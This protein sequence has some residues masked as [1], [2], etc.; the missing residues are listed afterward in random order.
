MSRYQLPVTLA[1]LAPI[2]LSAS[3]LR[4]G[5]NDVANEEQSDRR[6]VP[7]FLVRA[8][9]SSFTENFSAGKVSPRWSS[10][11]DWI[12]EDGVLQRVTGGKNTTR[13][14]LK[15]TAFSNAIVRFD[16]RLGRSRDLRLVTGSGGHYNAV[17]HIQPD[18]FYLQTAR[19]SDGPYFSRRHGECAYDFQHNLWYSMT[20][21]FLDHELVAYLD[22]EHIAYAEHP[23][24]NKERHY[25]AFQVDSGAAEIDNVQITSAVTLPPDQTR[26]A[27][28][29]E[30]IDDHPV[31]RSLADTYAIEKVNAHDRLFQS[32]SEYR[33]LVAEVD[34]LDEV[35][36]EQFPE[37]FRTRK[38]VKKDISKLRKNLLENE[39]EYK[40]LLFATYRAKR[41]IEQ[42]VI[43]EHPEYERLPDSQRKH[44]LA[45]WSDELRE[46]FEYQEL[47]LSR[48]AAQKQLEAAYPQLFVSDD[49]IRESQQL[50]RTALKSDPAFQSLMKK[51]ADAW[52]HQQQYLHEQDATLSEIHRQRIAVE[53]Q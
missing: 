23:I 10:S 12:V 4:G 5:P 21:E 24:L 42:Y 51:R 31:E 39:P 43:S 44:H 48:V 47:E 3:L 22:A 35:K 8:T 46:T 25:F 19:D 20:L 50:A 11:A 41:S 1:T 13:I 26:R 14:F 34:R 30:R 18:H 38:S 6:P 16:F 49:K 28:V 9:K 33:R 15:D 36:R 40:E 17:L 52:N 37:V 32:D 53:A 27:E 7:P 2:F 45:K 29:L